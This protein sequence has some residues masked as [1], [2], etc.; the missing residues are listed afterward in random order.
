M[1]PRIDLRE[2]K[3]NVEPLSPEHARQA[4]WGILNWTFAPPPPRFPPLT[5]QDALNSPI[6]VPFTILRSE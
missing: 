4:G 2:G 3:G 5:C 1:E 6:R